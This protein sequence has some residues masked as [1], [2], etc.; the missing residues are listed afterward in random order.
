MARPVKITSDTPCDIGPML[1]ERYGVAL[2]PLHVTM[3]DQ[4]YLDGVNITKRHDL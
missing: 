4:E 3:N 2:A 1:Q